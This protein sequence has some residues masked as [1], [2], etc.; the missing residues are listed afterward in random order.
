MVPCGFTKVEIVFYSGYS[1]LTPFPKLRFQY[2]LKPVKHRPLP[3][4][5]CPTARPLWGTPVRC[6]QTLLSALQTLLLGL[7]LFT[8]AA[9]RPFPQ[10]KCA[11][12]L[13][14][15]CCQICPLRFFFFWTRGLHDLSSP[16]R[17]WNLGPWQWK[18]WVLTTGPPR[19]SLRWLF[20]WNDYYFS[21]PKVFLG[22]FPN[23]SG[24]FDG[25]LFLTE[26]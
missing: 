11:P 18:H 22:S 12:Q 16:T 10:I 17:D 9:P 6:T 1:D 3:L 23:L 25:V 8:S 20:N 2:L 5:Q 19:N 21:F 4:D 26:L 7:H 24:L 15:L 14:L 13:G